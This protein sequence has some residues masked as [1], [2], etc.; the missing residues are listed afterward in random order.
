MYHN[1]PFAYLRH[2][3]NCSFVL[4]CFLVKSIHHHLC[5]YLVSVCNHGIRKLSGQ[6]LVK[7][8]TIG[9]DVRL[10]T[11]GVTVLHPDHLRSLVHRNCFYLGYKTCFLSFTVNKIQ[12][13][14]S[15]R[16][17]G[18]T[19]PLF[20]LPSREWIL[21]VARL[22]ASHSILF[23]QWPNQNLRSLPLSLH[24][25]RCLEMWFKDRDGSQDHEYLAV[26]HRQHD[27]ADL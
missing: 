27:P 17:I 3:W 7:Y 21:K 10:E 4:F 5:N 12:T 20:N 9:V 6:Q 25:G 1:F 13:N 8:N 18:Q 2:K 26:N 11:V 23:S 19:F 14:R 24:G 15:N 22:D 16:I